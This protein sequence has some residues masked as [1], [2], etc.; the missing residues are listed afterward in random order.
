MSTSE[1]VYSRTAPPAE[2]PT[3]NWLFFQLASEHYAILSP[4]VREITRCRLVTPVPGA[5]AVLPGVIN[6]RGLIL[7]VVDLRV[8]IGLRED[9]LT[10]SARLV[11]IQHNDVDAALLVDAV[12][13]LVTL[14]IG[15]IE[16][17]PAGLDPARSA[18]LRG[19]AQHEERT[20]ALFETDALITRLRE[21][22]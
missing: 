9:D 17:V 21:Y 7:P 10:R 11:I 2:I 12:F 18:L 19:V 14:P 13:D 5:P 1:F 3:L 16:P 22:S 6:H 20:I 4:C 15:A 8:L